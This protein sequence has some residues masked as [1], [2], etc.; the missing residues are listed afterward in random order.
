MVRTTKPTKGIC[1][2]GAEECRHVCCTTRRCCDGNEYCGD[3]SPF[4]AEMRKRSCGALAVLIGIGAGIGGM[5]LA[6]ILQLLPMPTGETLIRAYVAR[7]GLGNEARYSVPTFTLSGGL[8]WISLLVGPLVGGA[9]VFFKRWASACSPRAATGLRQ[10]VASLIAF[11]YCRRSVDGVSAPVGNGKG[12]A[13]LAFT[14]SLT[15]RLAVILVLI[16]LVITTVLRAGAKVGQLA[17]GFRRGSPG[18]RSGRSVESMAPPYRSWVRSACGGRR[19]PIVFQG[20]AA[21]S[22]RAPH[23]IHCCAG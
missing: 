21:Y 18:G 17:P 11:F 9:G 4:V 23:R 8:C 1:G 20:R 16:K 5:S 2:K 15:V 3:G 13:E 14:D 10:V 19:F 22:H 12:L 6:R 7:L